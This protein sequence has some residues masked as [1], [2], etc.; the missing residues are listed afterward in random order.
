MKIS[1]IKKAT[2][3]AL[4]ISCLA[5]LASCSGSTTKVFANK[6]IQAYAKKYDINYDV[7]DVKLY[8]YKDSEEILVS[9]N[10][11]YALLKNKTTNKYR[12]FM[13]YADKFFNIPTDEGEKVT[14]ISEPNDL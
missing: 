10:F 6:D 2:I 12:L 4:S 14:S 8:E 13:R 5:A 3:C 1:L 7:K 9:T 11:R